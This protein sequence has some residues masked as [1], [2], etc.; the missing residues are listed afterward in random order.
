MANT[1]CSSM[2][3]DAV[4]PRGGGGDMYLYL[5]NIALIPSNIKE[6]EGGGGGS[7]MHLQT[8]LSRTPSCGMTPPDT[9]EA[10]TCGG[11]AGRKREVAGGCGI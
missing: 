3:A 8:P 7:L 10:H 9:A 5:L 1:M 4:K 11:K 2:L 6:L